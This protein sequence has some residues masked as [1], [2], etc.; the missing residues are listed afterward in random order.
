ME[1]GMYFKTGDITEEAVEARAQAILDV[2]EA[3]LEHRSSEVTE[4]ALDV[5][6]VSLCAKINVS[7]CT[8]NMT[9]K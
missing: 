8:V 4:K 2:L 1:N 5:L 6:A 7:D 3:A 9:T